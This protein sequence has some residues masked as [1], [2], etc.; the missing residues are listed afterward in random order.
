MHSSKASDLSA[1][2]AHR[3]A[4]AVARKLNAR[5]L[6]YFS[7]NED[8]LVHLLQRRLQALINGK[9]SDAQM[10]RW[11]MARHYL[12]VHT[13]AFKLA[14]AAALETSLDKE[15]Q[16]I[17]RES[18]LYGAAGRLSGGVFEGVNLTLLGADEMD[19]MLLSDQVSQR[20]NTHYDDTLVPLTLRLRALFGRDNASLQNNPYRPA[21]LVRSLLLALKQ[22]AFAEDV[23]RSVLLA[24]DPHNCIDLGTLYKELDQLLAKSG[25]SEQMHRL[26]KDSE[27]DSGAES[28][29]SGPGLAS[30]YGSATGWGSLAHSAALPGLGHPGPGWP[31][32]LQAH[33]FLHRIA[34][35]LPEGGYSLHPAAAGVARY[36]G[37][38]GANPGLDA[39]LPPVDPYLLS[40]LEGLQAGAIESFAYAGLDLDLGSPNLL[41]HLREEPVVREAQ[42]FD[43]G[44]VDALA[45]VFDF[46]FFDPN[47]ASVLKVV[48]GRLQIPTLKAALLDRNFFHSPNHPARRLIDALAGAAMAWSEEKG[49]EDPLYLQIEAS[50]KRILREFDQDLALFSDVLLEF[51]E[52]QAH[53][54]QGL[55]QQVQHLT[56]AQEQEEALEAARA[57]VDGL[58]QE[59]IAALPDDRGRTAFLLPFLTKQWREVLARACVNE[60]S[61]PD[62]WALLLT[63]TDQLLWSVL[64]KKDSAERRQLVAVLPG[65]VR[66]LNLSLDGLTWHEEEREYFTRRLIAAHMN[67]IRSTPDPAQS[68]GAEL[69]D[70]SAGEEAVWM[71]DQRIA[72]AQVDAPDT[73]DAILEEFERGMWFDFLNDDAQAQRCRLTWVSPKRGRFLFTNREGFNAFVRSER[74]VAELLR[75]GRLKVLPNEALVARAMQHIMAVP[76]TPETA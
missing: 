47:I 41:R 13:P 9:D 58:I 52:F 54:E 46:V 51:E 7:K 3:S 8:D 38:P 71:L 5:V 68:Q 57:H 56:S 39:A 69:Q 75:R 4:R 48:I 12:E 16:T 18:D 50:V 28:A 30:S 60:A 49:L 62:R 19:L 72:A 32:A 40:H 61:D 70:Q 35:G 10:L 11:R 29:A 67:A 42:E 44:M 73:M 23:A 74:E 24:F 2:A 17:E 37:F 66:Q 27:T 33:E 20:F 25:I 64:P 36:P 14:F 76:D 59:R 31:V 45:E 26:R 55:T 65:L 43:R 34:A 22:C 21:V 15:V 63:S 6:S 1:G 53:A